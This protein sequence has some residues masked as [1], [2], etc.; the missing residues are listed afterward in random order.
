MWAP[1]TGIQMSLSSNQ[2]GLQ[3]YTCTGQNGTIPV[4]SGQ[5]H[6]T[7]TTYVEKFGCIVIETQD[8]SGVVLCVGVSAA[9]ISIVDRRYQPTTMGP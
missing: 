1:S 8:V 3:I 9:N 4:K 2:Q 5:Q 7:N 6:L